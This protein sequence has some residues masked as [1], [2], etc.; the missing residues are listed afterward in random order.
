MCCGWWEL[1]FSFSEKEIE[2]MERR[3]IRVNPEVMCIRGIS[4]DTWL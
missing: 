1:D 4:M 2:T 3:K